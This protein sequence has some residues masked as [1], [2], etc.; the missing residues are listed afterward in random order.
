MHIQSID[1][2][3]EKMQPSHGTESQSYFYVVW[4]EEKLSSASDSLSSVEGSPQSEILPGTP[5]QQ[6]I[7]PQSDVGAAA[8]PGE[9][10]A[11]NEVADGLGAPQVLDSQPDINEIGTVLR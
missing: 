6:E 4:P 5:E 2:A 8:M 3:R 10:C 1:R 9:G 7:V 11:E